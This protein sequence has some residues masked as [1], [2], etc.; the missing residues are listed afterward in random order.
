MSKSLADVRDEAQKKYN[1]T[2]NTHAMFPIGTRVRIIT[3][4]E[5]FY[6]FYGETGK[7]INNS[8]G[9]LGIRVEFD[10]PR[11]F[12]GG[13]IQK[14]FNFNPTSLAPL[15]WDEEDNEH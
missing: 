9:Y 8:G 13:Y 1:T 7:V 15:E 14:D 6:F 3:P 12:E 2:E 11:H 10:E 5:D 4:C